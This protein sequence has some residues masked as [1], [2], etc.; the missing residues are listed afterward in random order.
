MPSKSLC[1]LWHRC[2]ESRDYNQSKRPVDRVVRGSFLLAL[3]NNL[4]RLDSKKFKWNLWN[5]MA[6]LGG[7]IPGRYTRTRTL[8]PEVREYRIQG[9]WFYLRMVRDMLGIIEL[10]R[11]SDSVLFGINVKKHKFNKYHFFLFFEESLIRIL[12][13]L[14]WVQETKELR[15]C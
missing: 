12:V 3:N 14:Y 1:S 6:V 4:P 9:Q 13:L 5:W 2:S 7:V 11:I 8:R 10:E 15:D